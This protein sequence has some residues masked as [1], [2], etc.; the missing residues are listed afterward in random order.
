MG[1]VP[2]TKLM[3]VCMYVQ[4]GPKKPHTIYSCP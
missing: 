2:E 3:Y 4:G 1:L